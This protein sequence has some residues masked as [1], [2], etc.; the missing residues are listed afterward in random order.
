[1]RES[2]LSFSVI[3][4]VLPC[5]LSAQHFF[6]FTKLGTE[7]YKNRISDVGLRNRISDSSI[8]LYDFDISGRNDTFLIS[9]GKVVND[10]GGTWSASIGLGDYYSRKSGFNISDYIDVPQANILNTKLTKVEVFQRKSLGI[11]FA[12][13]EKFWQ[14][15]M[16][17]SFGIAWQTNLWYTYQHKAYFK[18]DVVYSVTDF[19][20][21]QLK[22]DKIYVDTS[23]AT[24]FNFLSL[25]TGLNFYATKRYKAFELQIGL[26]PQLVIQ[27][28]FGMPKLFSSTTQYYSDAPL[29]IEYEQ[30]IKNTKV[31]ANYGILPNLQTSISLNY[32]LPNK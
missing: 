29:V 14:N 21:N 15:K 10:N 28:L 5:S 4:F 8:S 1:M 22:P 12:L 16:Q 17:V 23:Q 2:F 13:S 31:L 32:F 20:G 6:S 26:F 18:K 3:F 25:N 24:Y 7:S 11:G 30:S 27:S 19:V 9:F